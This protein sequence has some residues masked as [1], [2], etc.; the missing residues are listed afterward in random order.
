MSKRKQTVRDF[1]PVTSMK[2][3][4]E[5]ISDHGDKIALAFYDSSRELHE[6]T[7]SELA[8][9][10]KKEA[11]GLSALGFK[12]KRIA[13]IGETSPEWVASYVAVIA[14]GNVAI[15]MD[16]E[17]KVNE[18]EGFFAFAVRAWYSAM[19]VL[20]WSMAFWPVRP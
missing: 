2:H 6:M 7:Y 16:K 17:L 13:I 12:N 11:A 1:T 3:F 4:C 20:A 5:K 14:S 9:M 10:I 18:I 15:P 8:L 19:S